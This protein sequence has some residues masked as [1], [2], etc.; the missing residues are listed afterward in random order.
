VLADTLGIQLVARW[1]DLRRCVASILITIVVSG[2][3]NIAHPSSRLVPW[4]APMLVIEVHRHPAVTIFDVR[5]IDGGLGLAAADRA[6][7]QNANWRS[8]LGVSAPCMDSLRKAALR[9]DRSER[10]R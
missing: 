8:I 4:N 7:Q 3:P 5:G 6:Y 10:P 9:D 2:S 1:G